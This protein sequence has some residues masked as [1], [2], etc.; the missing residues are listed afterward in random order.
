ME[1]RAAGTE[2]RSIT[3]RGT[4][5]ALRRP[6]LAVVTVS[7]ETTAPTAGE[8]Q[9]GT[10]QRMQAVLEALRGR[11]MDPADISTQQITLDPVYD[12][13]ESGAR[14]TGYKSTQSL[15]LRVRKFDDLGP[16]MDAA[17]GAG[18]T[19]IAGLSMELDDPTEAQAEAL[20]SA[21]ADA[22]SRAEALAA[23]AG[24]SLGSA[25]WVREALPIDIPRPMMRM[26]AA[27]MAADTPVA[28]GSTEVSAQVEVGFAI[29]PGEDPQRI[30]VS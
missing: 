2:P 6:D 23:A 27:E 29:E 24:V 26:A 15:L 9:S 10:S 22:R 25:L 4:G 18:A 8:A 1:P 7:V 30:P 13:R 28:A 16:I 12:Y 21:V 5:R 11:A 14:L 19:G 17:V 3:V 20:A